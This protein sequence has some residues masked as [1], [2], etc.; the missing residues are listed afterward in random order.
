MGVT[1][2]GKFISK[3]K[4]EKVWGIKFVSVVS[5]PKIRGGDFMDKV[6]DRGFTQ[7]RHRASDKKMWH[8]VMP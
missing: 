5:R 2:K 8:F 7:V 4:L 6:E 1:V 3:D